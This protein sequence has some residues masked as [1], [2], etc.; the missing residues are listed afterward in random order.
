MKTYS[1]LPFTDQIPQSGAPRSGSL[2]DRPIPLEIFVHVAHTQTRLSLSYE[3]SG[4]M[5]A[6]AFAPVNP[7][8]QR[9]DQLWEKT[10]FEFFLAFPNVRQYWEFNLSPSHDWNCYRFDD[11]RTAMEPE[12]A[13]HHSPFQITQQVSQRKRHLFNC[14]IELSPLLPRSAPLQLGVTMVIAQQDGALNYWALSHPGPQAD[15][16]QR[17]SWLI[18]LPTGGT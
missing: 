11:Y 12:Q 2:R 13:W 15:F 5:T 7:A 10:C 16:H 4:D 18:S 3:L 8:P 9:R 17:D 14:Q 6:I 1:L